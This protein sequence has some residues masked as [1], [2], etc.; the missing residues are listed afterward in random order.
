MDMIWNQNKMMNLLESFHSLVKARI[1]FCDLE[2]KEI[3]CYPVPRSEYCNTIRS[4]K[5]GDNA[6]RRC[7][8][9]AFQRAAK[10]K[11]PYVYQCHAGL[12]EMTAPIISPEE[13]RIGF[14]MI[15]Q[16]RQPGDLDPHLWKEIGKKAG[17]AAINLNKLK[18]DYWNLP[19]MKMD[20]GRSCANIL[21]ALA[22]YVWFDNYF[23]LQKEPLSGR[24]KDHIARNLDKPLSL[25]EIASTFKI[26]KTTLCKSIKQD[27]RITVNEL[28][29]SLRIEKAKQLLQS[30][31]LP[32]SAVAEQVGILDYNYFTKVFKNETGVTPSVFRKL[33]LNEYQLK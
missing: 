10:I 19:V 25:N 27:Y 20:Q 9:Y 12:I 28:I 3:L 31:E 22:V 15:G 33:C 7:D 6:C 30:R 13:G 29:R 17:V 2:G 4:N 1:G 32:V 18:T 8:E 24:V 21:Q 11:G 14:L 16:A 5:A 23:R 26:G